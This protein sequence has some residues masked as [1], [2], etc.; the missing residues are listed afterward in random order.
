MEDSW[1]GEPPTNPEISQSSQEPAEAGNMSLLFCRCKWLNGDSNPPHQPLWPFFFSSSKGKDRLSGLKMGTI[2]K[3]WIGEHTQNC[4]QTI[5]GCARLCPCCGT[6]SD[7]QGGGDREQCGQ[8]HDA[9]LASDLLW[10]WIPSSQQDPASQEHKCE[11]AIRTATV[12]L[13]AGFLRAGLI[14]KRVSL[15]I[16]LVWGT[17]ISPL[18][19]ATG[20]TCSLSHCQGDGGA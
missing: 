2:Y 3:G 14:Y 9:L 1:I 11:K 15:G 4:L 6:D 8:G 20:G 7:F 5:E 18:N 10:R 12:S 17:V 19:V 13:P 16:F